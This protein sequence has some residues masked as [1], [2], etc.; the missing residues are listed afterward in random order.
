[1]R[2]EKT[3]FISYRR[4]DIYVARAVYQNLNANGY[5]CF[6]D[7]ESIDSGS[8]ER[9][10]LNQIAARAQFLVILTPTALQRCVESGD[11]LRREIE[12]AL[13]LKRN[14]IPLMFEGFS[15]RGTQPY[16][17]GKLAALQQYNGLEVPNTYFDAA[18]ARLRDRFL[19]KSL[20]VILHPTPQEDHVAVQKAQANEARQP[21]VLPKDFFSNIVTSYADRASTPKT[22]GSLPGKTASRNAAGHGEP[23]SAAA[24]NN[25]GGS[26]KAAGDL[27]GALADYNEAIRLDPRY[28]LAYYNRG[29]AYTQKGD[30]QRANADYRRYV[31]LGGADADRARGLIRSNEKKL[32]G[33]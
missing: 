4:T 15:F 17:T 26:R 9:V 31:D 12:R 19:N 7:Y 3:V 11:W 24:Y 14:L 30:F 8:F 6:L 1:M 10:I 13:D 25:R 29:V 21:T 32:R 5:D 22:E 33:R 28:A 20:D 2:V 16:L 27:N 23:T 18:M